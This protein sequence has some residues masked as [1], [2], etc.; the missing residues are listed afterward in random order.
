M[1]NFIFCAAY[2]NKGVLNISQNLEGSI[3]VKVFQRDS[4]IGSPAYISLGTVLKEA[5][6]TLRDDGV[7]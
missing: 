2:Y 7:A 6:F 5:K 3:G 4:S 1:E